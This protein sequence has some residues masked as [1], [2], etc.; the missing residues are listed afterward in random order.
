M[1]KLVTA[2]TVS[3]LRLFSVPTSSSVCLIMH[4]VRM[5]S[6][7]YHLEPGRSATIGYCAVATWSERCP[8]FAGTGPLKKPDVQGRKKKKLQA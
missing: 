2:Q 7:E 3:F 4:S 1:T 5:R 8:W 6:T